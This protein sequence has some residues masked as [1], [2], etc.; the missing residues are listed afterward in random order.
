[1]SLRRRRAIAAIFQCRTYRYA[2]AQS[3]LRV[4]FVVVESKKDDG[5]DGSIGMGMG[6]GWL[7]KTNRVATGGGRIREVNNHAERV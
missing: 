5:I 2:V 7:E 4:Y 6:W 3:R 1:M